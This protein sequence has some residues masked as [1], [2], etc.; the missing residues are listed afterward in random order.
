MK[1]KSK[2]AA[3]PKTAP[4]R[5]AGKSTSKRKLRA[6]R[7]A[8]QRPVVDRE[9][10][11]AD[12]EPLICDLDKAAQIAFLMLMHDAENKDEDGLTMVAVEHVERLAAELRAAFYLAS[13]GKAVRT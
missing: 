5:K 6:I 9:Y 8:L 2:Q 10:A 12:L 1:R 7:S 4:R 13:D 3:K 11:L